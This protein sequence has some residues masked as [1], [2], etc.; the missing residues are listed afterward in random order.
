MRTPAQAPAVTLR[1]RRFIEGETR[2]FELR[3]RWR[4]GGKGIEESLQVLHAGVSDDL[5]SEHWDETVTTFLPVGIAHLFFF[6]GEQIADLA[7]GSHAAELIGTAI[8]TL[9]GLDLLERLTAD[10]KAFERKQRGESLDDTVLAALAEA[11]A[12]VAH[13]DREIEQ[14]AMAEGSLVEE[15]EGLAEEVDKQREAFEAAGGKLYQGR[16]ALQATHGELLKE[17]TQCEDA[18][19]D[20]VTGPLPLALVDELLAEIEAQ[21][22]HET[23]IR[24]AKVLA[25][26]LEERDR[27]LLATLDDE[28]VGDDTLGKI[29]RILA[30]DRADRAERTGLARRSL[31]LDADDRLA[32]QVAYLRAT[33][34][35]SAEREAS[36]LIQRLE[37]LEERLARTEAQLARIPSEDSIQV[38][39]NALDVAERN[40]RAKLHALDR[41][42]AQRALLQREYAEAGARLEHL[43]TAHLEARIEADDRARILTHSARVRATI[44]ALHHQAVARH[45]DNIQAL[46]LESF[47]KLL[48]KT[49]LVG[50]LSIDPQSFEPDLRD[51]DGRRLPFERLSAGERQL[52]AAALLWGLARASGRPIPAIIDT[53]LGRLDSSHRRNLVERY[54]PAASHQVLLL[55]TDEEII[56]H[57]YRALDPYIS[58]RYLLEYNCE[59][60][61]TAIRAGYF[62]PHEATSRP[63]PHQLQRE[64]NPDQAEET[65]RDRTL[66]P[67]LQIGAL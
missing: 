6:D 21:A 12:E 20:L 4:V 62:A 56:G 25:A 64:R 26:A 15:A 3:R 34:I 28:A 59:A 8:N 37:Q 10:L 23:G 51:L 16:N 22:C 13:L 1:F 58:R 14:I 61:A 65:N 46:M 38:A 45:T 30:A 27:A 55:S 41:L 49:D 19:R 39:H 47:C 36:R 32:A 57:S 9:L 44:E 50:S 33:R 48:G 52:L 42:R 63:H 5:L 24:H 53:P 17:K 18:L 11:E 35:P 67:T 2:S 40:H 54:F 7:D 43:S 66:E 31:L 60:H 29:R